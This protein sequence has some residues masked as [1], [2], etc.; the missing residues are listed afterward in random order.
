MSGFNSDAAAYIVGIL[1]GA[2]VSVGILSVI[3][4][5]FYKKLGIADLEVDEELTSLRRQASMYEEPNQ[6]E[7]SGIVKPETEPP[8]GTKEATDASDSNNQPKKVTPE[9]AKSIAKKA[10]AASDRK[11][12]W[13]F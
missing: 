4:V 7:R 11:Q 12:A 10:D 9:V 5:Y 6:A 2:L 8:Q 3:G 1:V 13:R